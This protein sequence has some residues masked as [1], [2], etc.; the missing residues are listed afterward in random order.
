MIALAL[1]IGATGLEVCRKTLPGSGY[2]AECVLCTDTASGESRPNVN[3]VANGRCSF[4][5]TPGVVSIPAGWPVRA[6][7]KLQVASGMT[8]DGPVTIFGS[9]AVVS[10]GVY[11]HRI[12]ATNPDI[13]NIKISD[14]LVHDDVAVVLQ[15]PRGVPTGGYEGS[16]LTNCTAV[17]GEVDVVV[18][19]AGAVT[20]NGGRLMYENVV[21][22]QFSKA[23]R[24]FSIEAELKAIGSAYVSEL[25]DGVQP[26]WIGT[27]QRGIG[28]LIAIIVVTAS[29]RYTL[30]GL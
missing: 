11:T 15:G 6:N 30:S 26:G 16:V 21:K 9:N 23:T 24:A 14:V 25:T 27:L 7:Q 18:V 4:E 29:T 13:A 19:N 22:M 5:P 28:W 12:A 8:I 1:L 17:A 10:G 3:Y 2:N 20:V